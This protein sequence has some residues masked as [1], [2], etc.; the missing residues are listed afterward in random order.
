MRKSQKIMLAVGLG[1]AALASG[2]AFTGTGLANTAPATQFLGGTVGQTVTGA[3]LAGV[4]YAFADAPANTEVNTINLTFANTADGR[5]VAVT[6]SGGTG[7]FTC[8]AVASNASTC[9]FTGTGGYTGL[10]S[11]DITV[12]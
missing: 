10:T 8:T 3:T 7:S 4:S 12:S 11:I 9:T 5:T 2:T 6:P 1:A